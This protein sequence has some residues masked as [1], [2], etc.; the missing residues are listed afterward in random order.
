M[1]VTEQQLSARHFAY[2][3]F[4]KLCPLASDFA[5]WLCLEIITNQRILPSVTLGQSK[6]LLYTRQRTRFWWITKSLIPGIDLNKWAIVTKETQFFL[7]HKERALFLSEYS[8]SGSF[9][10]R[11]P[12]IIILISDLFIWN[13]HFLPFLFLKIDLTGFSSITFVLFRRKRKIIL[14]F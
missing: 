9:L 11:F 4:T 12:C 5:I 10:N 13:A 1:A 14:I 2:Q 7:S 3:S 6:I 8:T